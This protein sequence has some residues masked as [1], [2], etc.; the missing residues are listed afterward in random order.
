MENLRGSSVPAIG[1]RPFRDRLP[2][3]RC[4]KSTENGSPK[5]LPDPEWNKEAV[6]PLA[7]DLGISVHPRSDNGQPAGKSLGNGVAPSLGRRRE[8]EEVGRRHPQPD[9]VMWPC[10]NDPNMIIKPMARRK[11]FQAVPI[12][13]FPLIAHSNVEEI[14]MVMEKLGKSFDHSVV[15]LPLP[16]RADRQKNHGLSWKS[17][18]FSR[19][20]LVRREK[21][22][23]IHAVRNDPNFLWSNPQAYHE[24]SKRLAY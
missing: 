9:L 7:Y 11:A 6:A 15:P 22:R 1:A 23:P 21:S 14:G 16:Q 19:L 3:P 8:A 17:E 10:R 12:A 2:V 4:L 18:L 24:L 13:A 5:C 20:P